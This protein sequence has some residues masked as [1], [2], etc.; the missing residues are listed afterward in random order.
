MRLGETLSSDTLFHF[1]SERRYLENIIENGF[2]PRYSK[3]D[4]SVFS[5][6]FGDD[7][8]SLEFAVPMIC[9]CDIP[10]SK[11]KE[12]ISV[13]KG[14]GIGCTKAWGIE[15]GISPVLYAKPT[16]ETVQSIQN[17]HLI[18]KSL[19]HIEEED[20]AK[21]RNLKENLTR[22]MRFVKPYEGRFE[23]DGKIFENKRFYDEREW[24][25][26]P[27]FREDIDLKLMPWISKDF[28]IWNLRTTRIIL[29][30][31][32]FNWQ[33]EILGDAAWFRDQ[34]MKHPELSV[35]SE[36][37][38]SDLLFDSLRQEQNTII[39]NTP[40]VALKIDPL[41]IKYIIVE[42]EEDVEPIADVLNKKFRAG[43][44]VTTVTR[45]LTRIITLEQIF[46]DF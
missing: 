22:L 39:E 45:L 26:V 31:S 40:E 44:S 24:R 30:D 32:K 1:T 17:A 16:S 41:T 15:K 3:E 35:R 21:L 7:L 20:A 25:Y 13:Y 9:F 8:E 2:F 23:H 28:I 34:F 14:Y 38:L 43:Y 10:L 12:H 37:D 27:N 18:L 6:A 11:V 42:K 33:S 19:Q 46:D 4:L 36:N 29:N 5:S